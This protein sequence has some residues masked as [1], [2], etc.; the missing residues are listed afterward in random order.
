MAMMQPQK[1]SKG[2]MVGDILMSLAPVAASFHSPQAQAQANAVNAQR[3]AQRDQDQKS[4]VEQLMT[5]FKLGQPDSTDD[6]K[7]YAAA[8]QQ[9]YPGTFFDYMKELKTP[10]MDPM[11]KAVMGSPAFQKLLGG[12]QSPAVPAGAPAAEAPKRFR[13]NPEKMALEQI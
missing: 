7:E 10:P 8:K 3:Y 5:M 2:Q 12:G 13:F 1:R 9:G 6:Q 11:D 4:K